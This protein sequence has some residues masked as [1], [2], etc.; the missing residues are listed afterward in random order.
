L[1]T[2]GSAVGYYLPLYDLYGLTLAEVRFSSTAKIS[3]KWLEQNQVDAVALSE[4]EF[5]RDRQQ[6]KPNEFRII[7]K[8]RVLPSGVVLL[9]PTVE[10]KQEE[11]IIR[12]MKQANAILTTDAGYIPNA[13]VPD[14]RQFITLVNKVKPLEVKLKNKPAIL[15]LNKN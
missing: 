13:K 11:Q 9:S 4:D 2:P 12:A 8:T 14:Y 1:G 5:Q 6:F 10:R 7:H 15:T 3:L